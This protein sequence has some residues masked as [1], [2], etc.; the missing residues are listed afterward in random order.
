[1]E[2]I[3]ISTSLSTVTGMLLIAQEKGYF[4]DSGLDVTF[5]FLP[6]G[7]VGVEQVMAGQVDIAAFTEFVLVSGIFAG[8]ESLKCLGAIAAAE[9]TQV[10]ARKDQGIRQPG[11][12]KGKLIGV[13]RGSNSEFFLGRFLTFNGLS[14]KDIKIENLDPSAMGEALA[15][16]KTDAVMVWEPWANNIMTRLV[17]ETV[18]WPGQGGQK[19]YWLLVTTNQLIQARPGVLE[20]LFRALKRAEIF[21]KNHKEE[22]IGIVAAYIRTPPAVLKSFWSKYEYAL[23][24]DQALLIAMEDEARWMMRHKLTHQTGLPNYLDYFHVDPLAKVD[25]KAMRL[26]LPK[27]GSKNAPGD[28]GRGKVN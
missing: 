13:F 4:G 22:S 21:I 26:I 14:I 6:S 18:S 24:L 25:P 9:D 2:K 27:A 16:G 23:S 28:S 10:I 17:D 8:G 3:T 11:D 7:N 20:R 15:G 19:Y 12:L 5:K 1:M